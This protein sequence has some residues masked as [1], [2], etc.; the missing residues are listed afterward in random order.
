KS[1]RL[2]I[3]ASLLVTASQGPAGLPVGVAVTTVVGGTGLGI[4]I[5]VG[6]GLVLDVRRLQPSRVAIRTNAISGADKRLLFEFT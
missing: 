2:K 5:L 1:G 6:V 3:V 4:V